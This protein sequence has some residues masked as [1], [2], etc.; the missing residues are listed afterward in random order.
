MKLYALAAGVISLSACA[1]LP[2]DKTSVPFDMTTGRP[3]VQLTLKDGSKAP[4]IFDTG[5]M[6]ASVSQSI[7]ASQKLPVV[8]KAQLSSPH[9]GTPM[10]V[11]VVRL[12][13]ANLGGVNVTTPTATSSPL[14]DQFAPG[15]AGNVV[16]PAHFASSVTELDFRTNTLRLSSSPVIEPSQWMPLDQNGFLSGTTKI[17]DE[18]AKFTID[19]GNPGSAVTSLALAKKW[20]P[21][22][23][24]QV[25]GRMGT[26]DATKALSI[27]QLDQQIDIAGIP[28]QLGTIGA[29]DGAPPY[30]NLGSGAMAGL[31]VIIDWPKRK[32][33]LV[34]TSP[35]PINMPLPK[36]GPP[37]AG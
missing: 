10:E 7:V 16:G 32:W 24:W 29:L 9:G 35:G 5:A 28:L 4:F 34:G 26:V 21:E 1:S 30:I 15:G 17:G 8:G 37:R 3:V 2:R 33:G 6:V 25:V 36:R 13:H 23:A 18:D 14:L 19:L 22:A 12:G 11:D 31:T 27:G 20:K